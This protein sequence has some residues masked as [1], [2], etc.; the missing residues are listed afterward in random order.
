MNFRSKYLASLALILCSSSAM[1]QVYSLTELGSLGGSQGS[2]TN[3]G[4]VN[5]A[6]Q[7]AGYSYVSGSTSPTAFIYTG[8]SMQSIG[9]PGSSEGYGINAAGQV[10]GVVD[11]CG[12]Y[13]VGGAVIDLNNLLA[14]CGAIPADTSTGVAINTNGAVAGYSTATGAATH[15][16]YFTGGK[17]KD[18]GTLGGKNSYA[19]ALN[20]GG[21]VTGYSETAAGANHAFISSSGGLTDIGTLGGDS[22]IGYG[23][24]SSGNI[25][26]L[27]QTTGN[28]ST[29]AFLYTSDTNEMHSLGGLG[30]TTSAGLAINN[31]G[32]IVG[33]ANNADGVTHAFLYSN[34][35]LVDLNTLIN[36]ND[37]LAPFVILT[38]A[39]GISSN[40]LIVAEG[41]D[42]RDPAGVGEVFLLTGID[43]APT[44]TAKIKGYLFN[45]WYITATTLSW[46]ITG[47]PVPTTSGCSTVSVPNTA[48]TTYTCTAT[49]SVGSKS[50]SVTLK[51]DTTNPTVT[52]TTPVNDATYT[53]GQVV[54]AAYTCADSISGIATCKGTVANG[55]PINTRVAGPISFTVH[56]TNNADLVTSK[57]VNY[58][59]VSK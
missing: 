11:T 18:L 47:Y 24:N 39:T 30:G 9:A 2:F 35:K 10:T 27:S 42:S 54:D 32:D 26:G 31:S 45:G 5:D 40:G 19:Y 7:V 17:I 14:K 33:Y 59:V 12:F 46:I 49:N 15:A 1:A 4:S 48:G 22:S 21:Q 57:T 6:G 56:A 37:P 41:I 34:K 44:V 43:T 50:A 38:S 53:V 13:T 8:G 20:G 29:R 58:T 3:W 55:A 23:I 36:P 51:V 16:V 25:T 52:I 28:A